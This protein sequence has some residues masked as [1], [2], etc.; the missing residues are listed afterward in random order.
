M[1]KKHKVIY[2]PAAKDDLRDIAAYILY[3]LKNPLAAKNV[4]GKIRS[5]IRSLSEMPERYALVDW[6][7]WA[8]MKMH[9]LPVA[10]YIAF[11]FIDDDH[12]TV[13]VTRIFYAGRDIEHIIQNSEP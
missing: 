2:S 12:H 13:T 4:T 1:S 7:P 10:N 8:S 11:Y 9:K 5:E 3:E 6:E